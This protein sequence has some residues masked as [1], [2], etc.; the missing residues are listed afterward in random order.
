MSKTV[1]AYHADC[2]D[3]FGAA[4]A[5]RKKLPAA[6]MVPAKY[7]ETTL[8]SIGM[9]PGDHLF[10]VD[11]SFDPQETMDLAATGVNVRVLDHHKSAMEKW[12][13]LVTLEQSQFI[14]GAVEFAGASLQVV[15]SELNSGAVLAWKAFHREVAVPPILQLVQDRDLWKFKIPMSKELNRAIST[16]IGDF[17]DFEEMHEALLDPDMGLAMAIAGRAMLAA[18]IQTM[19]SCIK[20]TYKEVTISED[21]GCTGNYSE[22]ESE[23]TLTVGIVMCPAILASE[24]GNL[25]LNERNIDIA[26]MDYIDQM[27]T[28]LVSLRSKP[29]G[30]DVS[31]LAGKYGGG[32]HKNAAGYRINRSEFAVQ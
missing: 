19:R 5:V 30:P 2:A 24:M 23:K 4:W 32:G 11:F 29:G 14:T 9:E 12:E 27:A 10:V 25:L 21:F 17:K 20:T 18:D 13:K 8:A 26:H 22:A 15:Y 31:V 16:V 7:Q 28:T 3:G 1:V 6:K